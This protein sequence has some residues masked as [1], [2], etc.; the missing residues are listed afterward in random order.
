MGVSGEDIK[1]IKADI[2]LVRKITEE[3]KFVEDNNE[4]N[5]VGNHLMGKIITQEKFMSDKKRMILEENEKY[6]PSKNA[7]AKTKFF[8]T[9]NLNF[10]RNRRK[11][12]M[13]Y[14]AM[15]N[16]V[17]LFDGNPRKSE[18]SK[19]QRRKSKN[20]QFET[21]DKKV[22][23][24]KAIKS[25]NKN[26]KEVEKAEASLNDEKTASKVDEPAKSEISKNRN[27]RRRK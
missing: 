11:N 27:S 16:V 15:D 18:N 2:D 14:N 13:E 1:E 25:A 10:K 19:K 26:S 4:L 7:N 6:R 20:Q 9:G 23:D 3:I 21:K 24:K 12:S 17:K 8:G 22:K 5:Q